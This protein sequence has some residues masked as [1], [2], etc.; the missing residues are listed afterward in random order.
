MNNLALMTGVDIPIPEF[1]V[2]IHQPTIK[3]ISYI[4]EEGFFI[5]IQ[6]LCIEKSMV[7]KDESLLSD[8]TNFQVFMTVLQDESNREGKRYVEHLLTLLFPTYRV[9]FTPRALSLQGEQPVTIDEKNFE[10]LQNICKQIFCTSSALGGSGQSFNPQ[11]KRAQEIAE[12]LAAGRKK[13][14][15]EKGGNK[16]DTLSRYLS[17]LTVGINGMSL[18]DCMDLTL[19]Q[20]F[21]LIER[22]SLYTNWDIDIRCRLA[23]G[24]PDDKPDDWMK[25]IHE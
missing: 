12:K 20:M 4:G 2:S 7:I 11:G 1:K 23:G 22:Y 8:L 16:S 15:A 10:I 6:Y 18:K 9:F 5:A 14:A 25:N 21:D 24:K 17:I 13:I 19:Y 3:E